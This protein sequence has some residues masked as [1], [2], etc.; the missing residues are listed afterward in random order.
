MA[1]GSTPPRLPATTRTRCSRCRHLPLVDP[2]W[3]DQQPTD[4]LLC[5]L[6]LP[7][8]KRM[9]GRERRDGGIRVVGGRARRRP[10]SLQPPLSPLLDLDLQSS[11]PPPLST[12]LQSLVAT[13]AHKCCSQASRRRPELVAVSLARRC[14]SSIQLLPVPTAPKP[15]AAQLYG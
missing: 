13:T 2:P 11:S 14:C 7:G 10:S 15:T 6:W 8:S 4:P 1:D 9:M 12:L 3:P 5:D